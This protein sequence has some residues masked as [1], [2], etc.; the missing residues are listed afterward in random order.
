MLENILRSIRY[1]LGI[2]ILGALVFFGV[3]CFRHHSFV[4][5]KIWERKLSLDGLEYTLEEIYLHLKKYLK[6]PNFRMIEFEKED[7][8][9]RIICKSSVQLLSLED[10]ELVLKGES[11][12][13][14]TEELIDTE[15]L[16]AAIAECLELP[17]QKSSKKLLEKRTLDKWALRGF[18]IFLLI[19]ILMGV[20]DSR[21]P[22][23]RVQEVCFT[24]YSSTMSIGEV[25]ENSCTDTKWEE[26]TYGDNKCVRFTGYT[27][28]IGAY[29]YIIFVYN[30]KEVEVVEV[31]LGNESYTDNLTIHIIMAAMY[32]NNNSQ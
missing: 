12:G 22:I 16:I 5:R 6:Y 1:G 7:N 9:I 10:G 4:K 11:Q 27:K 31:G 24:Q 18:V 26:G 3:M 20:L 23:K 25:L 28:S 13:E 32:D 17:V 29:L 8:R 14:E 30:D 15:C 2:G 19:V 21:S